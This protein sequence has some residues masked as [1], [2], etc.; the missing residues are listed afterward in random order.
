MVFTKLFRILYNKYIERLHSLDRVLVKKYGK[1][2][3]GSILWTEYIKSNNIKLIQDLTLKIPNCIYYTSFQY[4]LKNSIITTTKLTTEE[5]QQLSSIKANNDAVVVEFGK[6]SLS[7]MAL[8]ERKDRAEAYIIQLRGEEV[9]I[10]KSLED[11]YGK[12]TV[13]TATGEFTAIK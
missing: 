2:Y 3:E 4:C 9:K 13:N 1:D 8:K 11:K 10:A 12:G 5:I 7:E 6:I